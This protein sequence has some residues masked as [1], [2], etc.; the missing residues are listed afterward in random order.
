[1]IYVDVA[2]AIENINRS[3]VILNDIGN[4]DTVEDWQVKYIEHNIRSIKNSIE[5]LFYSDKTYDRVILTELEKT[6]LLSL[7]NNIKIANAEYYQINK[8]RSDKFNF[9][10]HLME[11]N[12]R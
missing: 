7:K 6:E 10:F 1:M 4:T 3:V 12:I 5:F 8:G 2:N 11:L 9:H